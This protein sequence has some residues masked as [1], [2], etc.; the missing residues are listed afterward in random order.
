MRIFFDIFWLFLVI[1]LHNGHNIIKYYMLCTLVVLL[2]Y[3]STVMLTLFNLFIN[4]FILI[5]VY[6]SHDS[7]VN[8]A[9]FSLSFLSV[10]KYRNWISNS[11]KVD[12]EAILTVFA[13]IVNIARK[14]LLF[15][16]NIVIYNTS[17]NV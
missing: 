17:W 10:K 14:N 9:K 4:F 7:S 11:I 13:E 3:E 6:F 15:A 2:Q 8:K 5:F 12:I 1:C 16:F